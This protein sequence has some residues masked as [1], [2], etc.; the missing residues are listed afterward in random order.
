MRERVSS[1]VDLRIN[2][3]EPD[4]AD[5]AHDGESEGDI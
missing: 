3:L 4:R 2:N 5:N 1:P